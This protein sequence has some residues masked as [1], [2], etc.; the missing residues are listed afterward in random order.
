MTNYF[1]N[2]KGLLVLIVQKRY[3]YIH[4]HTYISFVHAFQI[5]IL[6]FQNNL[7]RRN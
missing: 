4:V 6:S 3:I 5:P 1:S 7:S 2:K